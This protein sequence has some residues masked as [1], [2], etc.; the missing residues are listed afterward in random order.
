MPAT[1]RLPNPQPGRSPPAGGRTYA[2]FVDLMAHTVL[3]RH[4]QRRHHD[5]M[6][7]TPYLDSLRQDL[8]ASAALGGPEVLRAAELLGGS[9]DASARLTL[10]QVLADAAAEITARLETATIEVRLRWRE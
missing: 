10:M 2:G 8:S 9:L 5:V 3:V 6:D 4:P 1:L 7:L